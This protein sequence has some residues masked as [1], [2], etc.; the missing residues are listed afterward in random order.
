MHKDI[1]SRK[2]V[3]L[4]LIPLRNTEICIA[5]HV[6]PNLAISGSYIH[7]YTIS[8]FTVQV[9]PR[10][11]HES[12]QKV[13]KSSYNIVMGILAYYFIEIATSILV[14]YV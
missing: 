14:M 12:R 5:M 4:I 13:T 9:R 7:S 10:N 6:L 1:K 3:C 11:Y 2:N 8:C